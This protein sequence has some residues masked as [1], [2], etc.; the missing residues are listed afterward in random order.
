[1]DRAQDL[2]AFVGR[3]ALAALFVWS[4]FGKISGFADTAGYIA[5]KGLPVPEVL[6]AGTVFVELVLGLAL[7]MGFKTRI[8][9]LLIALWLIPTTLI[10]HN[11]WAAPA[12]EAAMQ[13]INFMKNLS[14]FGGMLVVMAFGA[15]AYSIDGLRAG[16][17]A[18]PAAAYR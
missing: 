14:I 4:G 2:L 10:F 5:S 8:A 1:M 6:A 15:G 17:P 7:A 9:A 12:A 13:Q 3:V 18:T 16:G 11:F